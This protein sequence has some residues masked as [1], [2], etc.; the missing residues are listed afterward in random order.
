VIHRR[1]HE[2]HSTA[3]ATSAIA[4]S[5]SKQTA[6]FQRRHPPRLC[7]LTRAPTAAPQSIHRHVYDDRRG[8]GSRRA[9]R[10]A[11]AS[12]LARLTGNRD[13]RVTLSSSFQ[14]GSSGI[15]DHRG[16]CARG[17]GSIGAVSDG[18]VPLPSSRQYRS[19]PSATAE[20][21]RLWAIS[22]APAFRF[23]AAETSAAPLRSIH[24]REHSAR[25]TIVQWSCASSGSPL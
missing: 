24:R 18:R 6:A 20:A 25:V 11:L 15:G 2:R 13:A 16:A 14:G 23:G 5:G 19:S 17:L 22:S 8:A 10:S 9:L 3:I 4:R 7:F 12:R 1:R 21:D